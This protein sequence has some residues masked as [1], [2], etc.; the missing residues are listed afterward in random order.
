MKNE[1]DKLKVEMERAPNAANG[2]KARSVSPPVQNASPATK[3]DK[4]SAKSS[5][6]TS[7]ISRGPRKSGDISKSKQTMIN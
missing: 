1:A 4:A 2:D 7:K 3:K 5:D 6:K